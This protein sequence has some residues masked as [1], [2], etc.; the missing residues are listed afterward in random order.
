RWVEQTLPL[1][2]LNQRK[3]WPASVAQQDAPRPLRRG[4]TP[5]S[6]TSV[7][8]VRGPPPQRSRDRGPRFLPR[9]AAG[10]LLSPPPTDRRAPP[11]G[12]LL[13]EDA[14]PE[15]VQRSLPP[16]RPDPERACA[17]PSGRSSE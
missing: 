16:R 14:A 17:P 13:S 9:G 5:S 15:P 8:C 3:A 12:C 2:P 7:R 4:R 6:S 1:L 11:R 10:R